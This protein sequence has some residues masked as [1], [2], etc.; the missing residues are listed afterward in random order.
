VLVLGGVVLSVVSS[1]EETDADAAADSLK[2]LPVRVKTLLTLAER[3]LDL[4]R[5][6]DSMVLGETMA[7]SPLLPLAQTPLLAST[8]PSPRGRPCMRI[9]S[10]MRPGL[11]ARVELAMA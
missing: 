6:A 9:H 7:F 3:L 8:V 2:K 5:A 1:V 4:R 10:F 11:L